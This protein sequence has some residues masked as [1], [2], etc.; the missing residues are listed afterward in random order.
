MNRNLG[1]EAVFLRSSHDG[2][3][4]FTDKNSVCTKDCISRTYHVKTKSQSLK[5]NVLKTGEFTIEKLVLVN[6]PR[7]IF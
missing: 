3:S 2:S 4:K 7:T 5:V 1:L 6:N